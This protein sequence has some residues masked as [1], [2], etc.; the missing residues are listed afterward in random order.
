MPVKLIEGNIRRQQRKL[1]VLNAS[2]R[3]D[4]IRCA[5]S[6]RM[7]L[8]MVEFML[9]SD[10]SGRMPTTASGSETP[11]VVVRHACLGN[12]TGTSHRKCTST[13]LA[14]SLS[15][16]LFPP[17]NLILSGPSRFCD[18]LRA[19]LEFLTVSHPKCSTSSRSQPSHGDK[20]LNRHACTGWPSKSSGLGAN[21]W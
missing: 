1:L 18:P 17:S 11:N 15:V 16:S 21:D 4:R 3:R 12:A 13:W 8:Q 10:D 2:R 5:F 14:I 9:N 6:C 19:L 7:R 20:K